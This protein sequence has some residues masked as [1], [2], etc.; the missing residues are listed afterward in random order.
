MLLSSHHE[1]TEVNLVT[2]VLVSKCGRLQLLPFLYA[3][4]LPHQEVA[5]L[6]FLLELDLA[7]EGFDQ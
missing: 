5:S 1:Q 3:L 6:S 7:P 4:L 2:V